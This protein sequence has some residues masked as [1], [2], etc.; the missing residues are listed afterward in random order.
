[1][2]E[3][4]EPNNLVIIGAHLIER[5]AIFSLKRIKEEEQSKPTVITW[6]N[7][8]KIK[9]AGIAGGKAYRA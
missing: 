1:M 9:A 5:L 3:F 8:L 6:P 7:A 4:E 2:S